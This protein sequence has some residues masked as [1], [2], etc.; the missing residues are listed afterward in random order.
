[1]KE[2]NYGPLCHICDNEITEDDPMVLE[3]RHPCHLMC[4]EAREDDLEQQCSPVNANPKPT[5]N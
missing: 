3:D 4:V 5:E 2:E 1:M